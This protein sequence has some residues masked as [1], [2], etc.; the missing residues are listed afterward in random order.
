MSETNELNV[1][2]AAMTTTEN[3]IQPPN[4]VVNN[5]VNDVMIL[6]VGGYE[7]TSLRRTLTRVQNSVLASMISNNESLIK[8]SKGRYFLDRDGRLFSYVLQYLR[9]GVP[10]FPESYLDCE[11]L[12]LEAEF[13]KIDDLTRKLVEQCKRL[14]I[15]KDER[16]IVKVNVGGRTFVTTRKTMIVYPNSLLGRIFTGNQ[17]NDFWFKGEVFFDRDPDLF[18]YVVQFLRNRTFNYSCT[19]MESK[20]FLHNLLCEARFF[21]LQELISICMSLI[22]YCDQA[23]GGNPPT[24]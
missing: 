22:R 6:N 4:K 24:M 12:R 21:K 19:S 1:E 20:D 9:T 16:D 10:F 2:M 14:A 3:K 11:M 5:T 7:Y 17:P 8:D 23:R 15:Q 18:V 13:Y